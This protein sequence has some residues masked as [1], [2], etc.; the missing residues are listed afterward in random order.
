MMLEEPDGGY[1]KS[2]SAAALREDRERLARRLRP[3]GRL[4]HRVPLLIGRPRTPGDHLGDVVGVILDAP[5]R[6]A[7]SQAPSTSS[8]SPERESL[9]SRSIA[10]PWGLAL[11]IG[12]MR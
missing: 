7:S 11:P 3:A 6:M 12:T 5:A 1:S 4:E 8:R 2:R 10:Q 9:P